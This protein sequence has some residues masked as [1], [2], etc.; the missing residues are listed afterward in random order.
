M[1]RK[2]KA[3]AKKNTNTEGN[4]HFPFDRMT[5]VLCFLISVPVTI[6]GSLG[7]LCAAH[8]NSKE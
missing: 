2:A 5:A 4:L 1:K 7:E 8:G 3:N 6:R